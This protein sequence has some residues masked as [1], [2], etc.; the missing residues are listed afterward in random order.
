MDG[1]VSE[2][3]RLFLG[4]SLLENP[5]AH[6]EKVQDR[7]LPPARVSS[8]PKYISFALREYG[9]RLARLGDGKPGFDPALL[10][11]PI[12]RSAWCVQRHMVAPWHALCKGTRAPAE[13][14][15]RV[16]GTEACE[17]RKLDHVCLG[18]RWMT[19][20]SHYDGF[21]R[22]LMYVA[23]VSATNLIKKLTHVEDDN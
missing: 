22:I 16:G 7:G 10:M 4:Y 9:G 20:P 15:G 3:S 19:L 13:S 2:P 5:C 1:S 14:L 11:G 18:D 21:R 23:R 6:L 17:A 12:L 8:G